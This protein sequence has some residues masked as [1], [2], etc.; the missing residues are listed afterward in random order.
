MRYC[1][2]ELS[3]DGSLLSN[4][5]KSLKRAMAA[6]Y[7]RELSTKVF[8]AQCRLTE[9]GFRQGGA[10]CYGLRRLL[11]G[12]NG[13]P[14]GILEPGQRKH[15]QSDRVILKPARR[16]NSPWSVKTFGSLSSNRSRSR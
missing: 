8:A 7:S 15:L 16:M 9:K 3:N 11:L 13:R 6:E 12:Q 14:K 4:V 2:E 5:M 10:A 1:A